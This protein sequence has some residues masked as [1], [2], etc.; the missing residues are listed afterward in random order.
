MRAHVTTV[1]SITFQKSRI[2][3]PGW[4]TKPWSRIWKE[5]QNEKQFDTLW[6]ADLYLL[7]ELDENMSKL[8]YKEISGSIKGFQTEDGWTGKIQNNF[9]KS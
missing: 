1:M 2:N 3:A 4:S 8:N 6:K 7:T 5:Q 9:V